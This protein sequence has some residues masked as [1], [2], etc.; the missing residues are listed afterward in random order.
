MASAQE[1]NA[2][3]ESQRKNQPRLSA[4][5]VDVRRDRLHRLEKLILSSRARIASAI[6]ADYAKSPTEVDLS[7]I[8][9]ALTEIRHARKH[10][11]KWMKPKRVAPTITLIGT[12]SE[13]RPEAKGVV[14]IISPWNFP[15]N[16]TIGP[17]A[18]AV[19]AGNC[20]MIK[21]SELTPNTSRC[22]QE[23]LAAVFPEDEV[24]V[25]EGG[26]EV[27]TSLLK[28]K[29][30]HIFFTGS[31]AV[32]KIVMKAAAEHL[33]SVTLELGGKSP[34]I[35]GQSADLD[36]AARKIAWGKFLNNGQVCIAPDYLLVE[37]SVREPFL[38]KL[39]L[40]VTDLLGAEAHR[41]ENADYG[42]LV[43][44]HHFKRVEQLIDSALEGGA[45]AFM[46]KASDST[47]RFIGPT[48]LTDVPANAAV[49]REEIFG[50]VL[51]VVEFTA[52]DEAL[53]AIQGRE[54]P[55]VLY[56]FSRDDREIARVLAETSAGGTCIND[57]L[58]HF[59]HPNLP[60]GGAGF[61]GIGRSHG[62]Y[63]F[64]AFSNMRAVL[65][66]KTRL[67]AAKLLYPPYTAFRRKVIDLTLRYF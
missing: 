28:K 49:L 35:V 19:A 32:G 65:R 26:V 58:I 1:I 34:V 39:R 62:Y 46:G 23:L 25:I 31:P 4:S 40:A 48:I 15:F 41:Q 66:Q 17:L 63:G 45:V 20:V 33:C 22:M 21:P 29:F 12:R 30:D 8:Y 11:A 44:D 52:I 60:F 37:A 42:R 57:T 3:Y 6:A 56:L 14:L 50:P 16:L 27:A 43:N 53:S 9:P 13:I 61:S 2:I 67:S 36:D 47:Q 51:P 64:E 18:S 5:S 55:L 59:F 38:N 10:L 54:K 7:E 24:A